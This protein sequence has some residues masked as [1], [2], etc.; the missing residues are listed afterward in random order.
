MTG[1]R[2][3]ALGALTAIGI[4]VTGLLPGAGAQAQSPT[5]SVDLALPGAGDRLLIGGGLPFGLYFPLAGTLCRLLETGGAQQSCAVASLSDSAAAIDALKTGAMPFAIVQSDW[6]HH[7]VQGTSRYQETGPSVELRSVAS[8]YSEAFTI[9]VKATGPITQ[10]EDLDEKRVSVGPAGSY[11]GILADVAL[12]VAGLDRDDL[13]EA[14][15]EPVVSAIDRLCE[16]QTDAV[17][18]MAVHPAELLSAAG[19][20]CGIAPLSFSDDEVAE[21]LEALLGYSE[22]IIPA[23]TYP[24]Q[25]VPVRT[26]GLRPVLATTVDADPN[27]VNGLTLAIA[28]GLGRLNA[29]HPAFASIQID[30]LTL[31]SY[32]APLHPAAAQALGVAGQ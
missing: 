24:G 9:F 29:S 7:A 31:A 2:N 27:L 16:G 3:A 5:T 20:R 28:R 14:S 8:F 11:R 6:L 25:A 26:V 23:R 21:M 15:G 4:A 18:V 10:L 13:T 1:F 12:D 17:V 22:V 19:R 32:F 30:D